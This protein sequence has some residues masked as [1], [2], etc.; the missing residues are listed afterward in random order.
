VLKEGMASDCLSH[1]KLM[2]QII[3]RI[4]LTLSGFHSGVVVGIGF[5]TD[6]KFYVVCID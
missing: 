5:L 2:E 3:S 4:I 1:Q 6:E